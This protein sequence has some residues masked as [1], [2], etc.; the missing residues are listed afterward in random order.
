[1]RVLDALEPVRSELGREPV[2]RETRR[3]TLTPAEGAFRVTGRVL[4]V[5]DEPVEGLAVH[6]SRE[7]FT[8]TD[9]EGRFVLELTEST[10]LYLSGIAYSPRQVQ[11]HERAEVEFRV[12]DLCPLTLRTV[13]GLGAPI[14]ADVSLMVFTDGF[15]FA[16]G[17]Y[18]LSES[19]SVELPHA[20]CGRATVMASVPGYGTGED[21]WDHDQPSV[22][23]VVI[24]A[25]TR[26]HG[27][28]TR[29]D[30]TPVVG[31]VRTRSRT[32]KA[33][34]EADGTWELHLAP[35]RDWMLIANPEDPD[36]RSERRSVR[37][38]GEELRVD[39][40]AEPY[41]VVDVHCAGLPEDRCEGVVPILCTDPLSPVGEVCD[42][43]S[44]VSCLCPEGRV[45][46]RG[47]GQS[48]EVGPEESVAW[49]DFR[50][51]GGVKGTVTRGGE[52]FRCW[53][54]AGRLP[55]GLD[56]L[57]GGGTHARTGSCDADGNFEVL[58]LDPGRWVVEIYSS[59]GR[60]PQDDVFV[61]DQ[62]VDVGLIDLDQGG[63]IEVTV[64]DGLTGEPAPWEGVVANREGRDS[65][66]PIGNGGL[67][68]ADGTVEI[69]G[70]A[71]GTYTVFLG[72]RP[73]E[74]LQVLVAG[75][76]H[77]VTLETG[78][79][80]L[81]EENGFSVAADPDGSLVISEVEG[82]NGLQEGDVV[83]GV[84]VMG[85][86]VLDVAPQYAEEAARWVLDN[87]SGPGVDLVV[88]REDGWHDVELD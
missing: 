7:L 74:Q 6:A 66:N 83:V 13:D 60:W 49:L 40:V 33:S 70:L 39:F 30:G 47:G 54:G 51:G 69:T 34:V 18:T 9:A 50:H 11:V 56:E 16:S 77:A 61:E 37:I 25:G 15:P 46:I 27:T 44:R 67:S 79:A 4:T 22:R 58:G 21:R 20:A 12:P 3:L 36:L 28:Y 78:E 73:L 42:D 29:R 72:R 19:G 35:D 14:T 5:S 32:L 52:P 17:I 57:L 59:T 62:V 23:T 63:T 64:V 8:T 81:L 45:A 31:E 86:D 87:Y 10:L 24:E 71:E 88:E 65:L 68:D 55:D 26:V 48:V 84:A 76:H 80:D 43:H 41:R 85:I 75:D 53:Y 38:E 1:M 82:D 2:E